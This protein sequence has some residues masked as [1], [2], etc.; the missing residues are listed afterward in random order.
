M[1]KQFDFFGLSYLDRIAYG[2]L[3]MK[4]RYLSI[5]FE[6]YPTNLLDLHLHYI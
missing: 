6:P 5:D 4:L 3:V 2:L 1:H